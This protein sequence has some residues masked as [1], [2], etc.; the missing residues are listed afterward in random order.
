MPYIVASQPHGVAFVAW[1]FNVPTR[2]SGSAAAPVDGAVRCPPMRRLARHIFTLVSALSLLLCVAVVALWMRSHDSS[3]RMSRI[4]NRDRYTLRSEQG[5]LTLFSP[6]RVRIATQPLQNISTEA[7]DRVEAIISRMDNRQLVWEAAQTDAGMLQKIQTFAHPDEQVCDLWKTNL[8]RPGKTIPLLLRALERPEQ[9]AIAHLLL[10]QRLGIAAT[11]IKQQQ[12][13]SA[14][15]TS[16][17]LRFAIRAEAPQMGGPTF[18]LEVDAQW[19]SAQI[20]V[21]QLPAMREQ[22]HRRL[23]VPLVSVRYC[24]LLGG[25]LALPITGYGALLRRRLLARSRLRYRQCCRCGYDLRASPE[26]CPECGTLS[27]PQV[28]A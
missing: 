28:P 11:E 6:P 15:Y 16:D 10:G 4:L 26:R 21:T 27:S 24:W 25:L 5:R 1:V 23:D 9:F 8:G 14:L 18:S 17:G 22:W 2:V 3:D 13:G 20:D 7:D 12:P 19:C